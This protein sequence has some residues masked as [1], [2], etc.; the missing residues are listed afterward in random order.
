MGV[1]ERAGIDDRDLAAPD[2]VGHRALV[3]ER[4]RIVAQDAPHT[5]HD[6]LDR[7]GWQLEALVER[8]VVAHALTPRLTR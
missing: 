8:D 5:R 7:V 6:L 4:A 2:D 3:G 1:V